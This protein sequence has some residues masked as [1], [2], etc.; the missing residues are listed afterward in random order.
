MIF[1]NLANCM[2]AKIIRFIFYGNY[3]VG[4]LAVALS[5]EA[6]LQLKLPFNTALYFLLLFTAPTVYYTYAYEKAS[7][8]QPLS[9]LRAQWYIR[10]KYLIKASQF[11]LSTLSLAIIAYYVLKYFRNIQSLSVFYWIAISVII[12]SGILYYGLIP[13]SVFKYNLRNTGWVKAFV[14]GFTWACCAN[15]VP[16]IFLRVENGL[17][18]FNPYL[19]TWLFVKNWMFCTVNAI[20]FDIKDYPTDA[21]LHLR[22]FVVRFGLRKT[23]Y[24]ILIPLSVIGLISFCV[25]GYFHHFTALQMAINILPFLLTIYFAYTLHKKKSLLFYLMA[26]DGIIMFKALCGIIAVQFSH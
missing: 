5:I 10:H 6:T 13:K 11:V 23:I 14:I 19:W 25:F 16:L 21:N 9:N 17:G 3:F 15:I 18:Y 8:G 26:I 22:T 7:V 4:L 1:S 2:A 24:Y 20:M 12:S